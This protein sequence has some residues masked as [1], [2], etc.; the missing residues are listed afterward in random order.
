MSRKTEASW[1]RELE[2]G[3]A[4]LRRGEAA[5]AREAFA[6]AH[7]LA[8]AEPAPALAFGREEWKL[9]RL[10]EAERLLRLAWE[11][12]PTWPLAAAALAR[13]LIE[14]SALGEAEAVLARAFAAAPNHPALWMVRGELAFGAERDDEAAACFQRA[15]VCGAEPAAVAAGLARVENAR[16][17]AH[18]SAGREHEAAFAFKRSSDLDPSWAPPLVNLGALMQRLGRHRRARALYRQALA[19]DPGSAAAHYNLGL[20]CRDL[21]DLAGAERAFSDALGADPGHAQARRELALVCA[22]RGDTTN[23]IAL[24]EAELRS[25]R[26]PEAAVYTNLGVVYARAG[27]FERAEAAFRQALRLEPSQPRALG[28]LAQLLARAGRYPEAAALLRRAREAH[29]GNSAGPPASK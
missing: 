18:A 4:H 3:A 2:R 8:P 7:A 21:G 10:A 27:D 19:L 29:E 26:R 9:G 14:R 24:L 28:N 11:A 6:R 16:G 13:V 15:R 22:E 20:L 1:R 25:A 23:A 5:E 12:R 17:I